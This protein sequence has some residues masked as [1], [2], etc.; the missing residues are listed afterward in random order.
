EVG[1]FF[2]MWTAGLLEYDCLKGIDWQ[3]L[4]MDGSMTKAPLGGEKDGEK[5]HRSRQ[6]R[7]QAERLGRSYGCSRRHRGGRRQ[8]QR[9][10]DGRRDTGQHS[11]RTA[12]ANI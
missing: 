3:W 8:P 7:S 10:E 1:V 12:G 5:P 9:H 11:Y 4:S 6:T 2:E